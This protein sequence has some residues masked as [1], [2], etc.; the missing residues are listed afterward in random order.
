MNFKHF[1]TAGVLTLELLINYFIFHNFLYAYEINLRALT[2]FLTL[3][4][5]SNLY[6]EEDALLY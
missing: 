4:G 5:R 6:I 3:L 2:N 1:I